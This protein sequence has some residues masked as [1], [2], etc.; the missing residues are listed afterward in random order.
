[1]ENPT[2]VLA[3]L[4]GLVFL[5]MALEELFRRTGVPDV[6]VLL[7]LGLLASLTGVLDT[8]KLHGID[9]IFTTTALVL[10]LFEGAARLRLSELRSALGNSLAITFAGFIGTAVAVGA[11]AMVLF[12]MRPLAALMLGCIV[13]GTSSAVVIPMVQ[14]LRLNKNTRTVLTLE[15]ALT[16]VLAIVFTL[17][18][19]SALT[20]GD[21]RWSAVGKDL[22]Y[23]FGMALVIGAVAGFGWAVWLR[24]LRQKRASLLFVAAAV[25]LVYA[26]AEA[27]GTFGAIA[28]LSF[29]VVLG[30]ADSL[31]KDRPYASE[32]GMYDGER[33]FLREMAFLLK[34][35]FFVYLGASLKLTGYQPIVFG[36]L[37]TLVIF[38][39]RPFAVRLSMRARQTPK[40]DAKIAAVLVPKG[41]ASA[42]L[43]TVPLQAGI[44][45]GTAIEAITF[46][47]ILFTITIASALTI[48]VDKA[49]V[50]AAYDRVF[51][52]YVGPSD[53]PPDEGALVPQPEGVLPLLTAEQAPALAEPP[54]PP[55]PEKQSA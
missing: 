20:A 37:T 17:A 29:G 49:F 39:V 28:C 9:R 46:G 35:F 25:F 1:M 54:A 40:R 44:A 13:G 15:S 51:G 22:A 16:D 31:M 41:L 45:E 14:S 12:D 24:K 7:G 11:I 42:V 33:F 30:N 6:L 3:V 19:A 53:E 2:L 8:S 5:G 10:I 36:G 27:L 48:F 18:L 38:A 55:L 4:A 26:I 50:S 43:A 47:V 32:L 34:V 52:S 21:L 23:G